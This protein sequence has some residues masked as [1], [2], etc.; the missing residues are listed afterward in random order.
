MYGPSA[1]AAFKGKTEHKGECVMLRSQKP[2]RSAQKEE[3][4]TA[5]T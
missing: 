4:Q 1:G 2:T 5:G 3:V